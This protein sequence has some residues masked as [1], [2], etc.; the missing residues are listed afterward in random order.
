MNAS[1]LFLASLGSALVACSAARGSTAYGT[2]NN[3]D[4]VND[5]GTACHGFEVEIEDCP[6]TGITYTYD[7]N[8]Y[9]T[10][11]ITQDDSIPGHPRCLVRWSAVRKPD[12]TWSAY[13][14]VPTAPILPTDGHMFTNPAV[15][16]GGEHFGVG[17]NA[18]AASVKYFWLV[19]DGAG[20]L[21]RG[22][23]VQVSTP[24][25]TYYPPPVAGAAAQVQAAIKPPEAPEV[26][27]KEFGPAVWVKEIRTTTHNNR[28]V[29][30]R[31]LVSDDPGDAGDRNWRNDEPDEVEFEWEILQTEFNAV[32][33]GRKG[34]L[35]AAGEDLPDGDEVVT[36][37]YEFFEYVGPLDAE[38][39]EVATDGVGPDGIHGDGVGEVNGVETDFSTIEVVGKFLGSQMS[40]FNPDAEVGLAEHLQ[41]GEVGEPYPD[42]LVV[43]PGATPFSCMRSGDLPDGLAFDEVTGILSG[44][45][46]AVGE[47]SFTIEAADAVLPAVAKTYTIMVA[48]AGAALA[49]QAVVDTIAEPVAGG[50]TTGSGAYDPGQ[51]VNLTAVANPGYHFVHWTDQDIVVGDQ[52][53]YT[54]TADVHH[55]VVAHFAAEVPAWEILA[56]VFPAVGGS[57][58]GAG[59]FQDGSAVTLVASAGPGYRFVNWTETG[60]QVATTSTYSFPASV[61]RDL[62]A[63]FVVNDG[64]TWALALNASP[65]VG[66]TV[67]G[68]GDYADESQVTVIAAPNPGYLFKRWERGNSKVS[69]KATYR[70]TLDDDLSLTARFVR[71]YAISTSSWPATAGGTSGGGTFEDGNNVVVVASPA[72]GYRFVNWTENG[73][74]V[75]SASTYQFKANP[76]R[77]LTA[78]FD[79][80]VPDPVMTNDG[81]S[82]SFHWPAGLPGWVLEEC[83]DLSSGG[84]TECELEIE[85]ADGE[86]RVHIVPDSERKFF[87]LRHP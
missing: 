55:A 12:G 61:D 34:K 17:I 23:A 86:C 13:T 39:G 6:S 69:E 44:T 25:F 76:A 80:V 8:H 24:S 33:G 77:N 48:E 43:I 79:L 60:V 42:R 72:A 82:L 19:D 27:V 26:H 9:G 70:F 73:T 53:S 83:S 57:V 21:V 67:S 41:N 78:N 66:G 4:V 16:F 3:F 62:T 35:E 51:A 40:A 28:E 5:T 22:P 14:A 68:G 71:G 29:K 58:S 1:R 74:V 45:P 81:S 85:A 59:S 46:V 32:G 30:L 38:S 49:P 75:S 56:N 65:S 2:I 31:D 15:N 50:I 52:P 11:K 64:S 7:W 87:R 37:R 18:N 36:R 84:W 10:C 20:A 63:N 47:F 54:F